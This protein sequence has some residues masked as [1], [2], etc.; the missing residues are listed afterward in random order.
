MSDERYDLYFKGDLLDGFYADFVKVDMARLF[1]TDVERIEAFFS[2]EPQPVKLNVDKP[3]AAK[4]QQALKGIGARVLI[5]PAG[6]K[7]TGAPKTPARTEAGT[8]STVPDWTILPPGSDIGEQRDQ[9]AVEVDTSG[10]SLARVGATLADAGEAPESIPVDVSALSLARPGE[11]LV[12][13]DRTPP[14]PPPDT[15]HLSTD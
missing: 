13:E 10:L 2:G 8:G 14:P 1:K 6:E 4:Y 12:E 7:P 15:S 9:P 5:V 11:R 3:V